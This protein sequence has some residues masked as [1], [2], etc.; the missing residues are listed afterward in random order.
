[1]TIFVTLSQLPLFVTFYHFLSPFTTFCHLLPLSVTF[2]HFLSPFTT[3]CH[4]LLLS[5]TVCHFVFLFTVCSELFTCTLDM[6]STLLSWLSSDFLIVPPATGDENKKA[7]PALIRKIKVRTCINVARNTPTPLIL[8][9]CTSTVCCIPVL[10]TFTHAIIFV[11]SH[12]Y[13]V[14]CALFHEYTD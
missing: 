8:H 3:F 6:V 7:I 12:L 5:V 1:M 10:S 13:S 14:E 11:S 9:V 4:H 2:Y